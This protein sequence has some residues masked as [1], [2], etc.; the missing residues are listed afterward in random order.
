MEE[1]AKHIDSLVEERENSEKLLCIQNSLIHCSPQIIKPGRKLV[2]EGK[3]LKMTG[4]AG[5]VM[6]LVAMTDILLFCK[7][8]KDNITSKNA[9]KS[10]AILPLKKCRF[11]QNATMRKIHIS[12]ENDE[13]EM[14]IETVKEFNQWI[15]ALKESH[16][17]IIYNRCTLRKES[18]ARYPAFKKDL[19]CYNEVG[20]S[21]SLSQRKRKAAKSTKNVSDGEWINFKFVLHSYSQNVSNFLCLKWLSV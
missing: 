11:T 5:S 10:T 17:N 16:K 1:S 9:L 8:K 14:Y 12:C 7:I 2:K 18:S 15:D 19:K 3:V 4:M 13:I 20:L 6:Y 21:P